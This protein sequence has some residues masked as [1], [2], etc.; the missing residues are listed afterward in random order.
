MDGILALIVFLEALFLFKK[1][2][3]AGSIVLASVGVLCLLTIGGYRYSITR[4]KIELRWGLARIRLL[5]LR[6]SEVS[7]VEV[8]TSGVFRRFGGFGFVTALVQGGALF[9]V[10]TE[11]PLK[12][13]TGGASHLARKIRR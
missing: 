9:Y 8:M 1:P 6:M 12:P 5:N 11:C 13:L 2:S 10:T 3:L 7:D 4:E